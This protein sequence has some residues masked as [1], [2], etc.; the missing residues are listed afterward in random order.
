MWICMI[1]AG[2]IALVPPKV[3]QL[4][5]NCL[6]CLR[7]A[8]AASNLPQ[9]CLSEV[10]LSMSYWSI[11]II[12]SMPFISALSKLHHVRELPAHT[13][14]GGCSYWRSATSSIVSTYL[15][16]CLREDE[17]S[18]QGMTTRFCRSK[19]H[20]VQWHKI[21]IMWPLFSEYFF[22]FGGGGARFQTRSTIWVKVSNLG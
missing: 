15:C 7:T 19:W 6:S 10:T 20:L 21:S 17:K 13:F 11:F 12:I 8:S 18:R 1:G 16:S 5:Q 4:P 14:R 9:P 2:P 22:F 3:P